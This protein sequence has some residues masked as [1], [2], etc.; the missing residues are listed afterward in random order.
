MLDIKD[1][2][3]RKDY[4]KNC[5]KKREF[6]VDLDE[7]LALYDK[8]MKIKQEEENLLAQKNKGAKEFEFAKR[9]G[10]NTAELQEK[11]RENTHRAA[12]LT[13]EYNETMEKFNKIYFIKGH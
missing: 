1:I 9:N 2:K 13:K 11:L 8:A 7:M 3:E 5:F 4:Y 10:Q 12:E 6:E